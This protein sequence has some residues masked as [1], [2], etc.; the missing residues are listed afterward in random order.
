MF[1]SHNKQCQALKATNHRPLNLSNFSTANGTLTTQW[2]AGCRR[3]TTSI[4]IYYETRKCLLEGTPSPPRL[5][6]S[7][8]VCLKV[9]TELVHAVLYMLYDSSAQWCT[10]TSEQ[11]LQINV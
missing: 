8:A 10:H 6:Q 3:N 9:K 11:F 5:H 1:T 4:I 7:C 2:S